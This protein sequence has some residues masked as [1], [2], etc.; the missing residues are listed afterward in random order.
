MSKSVLTD[1]QK[2]EFVQLFFT[3]NTRVYGSIEF[4]NV[5]ALTAELLDDQR[6][7]WVRL[8]SRECPQSCAAALLPI[9]LVLREGMPMERTQHTHPFCCRFDLACPTLVG[10][11]ADG[12]ELERELPPRRSHAPPQST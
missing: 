2:N 11:H 1:P 7:F 9:V 5:T 4:F 12:A 6:A 10:S 8:E 3:G